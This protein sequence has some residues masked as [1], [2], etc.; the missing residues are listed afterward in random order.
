MKKTVDNP[1]FTLTAEEVY[2][3]QSLFKLLK[4]SEKND[5][6]HLGLVFDFYRL[7]THSDKTMAR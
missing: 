7:P 2:H 6:I 4:T 5:L 3:L 1:L